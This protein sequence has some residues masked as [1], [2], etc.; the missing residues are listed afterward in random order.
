VKAE[1]EAVI[2]QQMG[3]YPMLEPPEEFG[4]HVADVVRALL[5]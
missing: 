4:R 2:M 5:S 1:F 3:H